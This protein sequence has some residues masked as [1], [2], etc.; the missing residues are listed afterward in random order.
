MWYKTNNYVTHSVNEWKAANNYS[1]SDAEKGVGVHGN[2]TTEQQAPTG[3]KPK[4]AA[5]FLLVTLPI[6]A[7]VLIQD[8]IYWIKKY[9]THTVSQHLLHILPID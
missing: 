6:L 4:A 1:W 2:K 3:D 5:N 8:G 7:K 9:P